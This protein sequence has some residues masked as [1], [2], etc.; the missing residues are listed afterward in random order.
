METIDW[1]N[2]PANISAMDTKPCKGTV[3]GTAKCDLCGHAKCPVCGR[4]NVT[5]LSRVTGYIGAVEGWNEAKKQEL[6]D[7]QRTNIGIGGNTIP[8]QK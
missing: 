3:S 5:Q 6:K 2:C 7:R 8:V 1:H 4:Y